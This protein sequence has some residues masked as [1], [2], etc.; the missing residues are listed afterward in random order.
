MPS[1]DIVNEVDLQEVDNAVNNTKREVSTR[2]DFRQSNT[3]VEFNRK[4][5]IIS[6]QTSD[7]MKMQALHD[8]IIGNFVKRKVDPK[9]LEFG[10]NE[11]S[12]SGQIR[13]KIS[14]EE[15]IA[16]E[17]A[18]K[19]VK[20]VKAMK[21]KVQP[22]I[23]EDQVRVTGKKIDDLQEVISMLRNEDLGIPLQFTNMK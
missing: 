3:E 2:Y 11:G 7:D 12:S 8:M 21:L 17:T 19:I 4:E 1:V 14:I 20:L 6:L 23:Q 15:G 5:K 22:A 10:E 16:K 18:Q 13:C 9:C